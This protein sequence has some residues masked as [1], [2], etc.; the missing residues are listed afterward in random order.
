MLVDALAEAATFV[1]CVVVLPAALWWAMEAI[2]KWG[3]Q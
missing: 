3:R 2:K 1:L